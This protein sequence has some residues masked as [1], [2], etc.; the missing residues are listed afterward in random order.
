[1]QNPKRKKRNNVYLP[2]NE[3]TYRIELVYLV[4]FFVELVLN[5][6]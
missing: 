4:S 3:K 1:M 2:H 6:F 5:D